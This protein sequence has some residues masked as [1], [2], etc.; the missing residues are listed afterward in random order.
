MAGVIDGQ[1]VAAGG[2]QWD[3]PVWSKGT[4]LITDQIFT[5]SAPDG[6]WRVSES[7]LPIRAAHFATTATHNAIYFAGGLGVDGPLR[8][9]FKLGDQRRN[10]SAIGWPTCLNQLSTVGQGC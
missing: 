7:R 4:R 2:S 3:K 1:L 8:T 5:L 6:T 9:V 10:S